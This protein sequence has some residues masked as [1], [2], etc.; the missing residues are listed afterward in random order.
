MEAQLEE[1]QIEDAQAQKEESNVPPRKYLGQI[2]ASPSVLKSYNTKMVV[3]VM[4][5]RKMNKM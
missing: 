4:K 3:I 2:K 1:Y 5:R